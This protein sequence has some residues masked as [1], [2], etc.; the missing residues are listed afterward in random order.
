MYVHP[1][2]SHTIPFYGT[3][4]FPD[5]AFCRPALLAVDDRGPPLVASS[6]MTL[7]PPSLQPTGSK[8]VWPSLGIRG[9]VVVA[10]T[11]LKSGRKTPSYV[12]TLT[13][14]EEER[15]RTQILII[16]RIL[17]VFARQG[18]ACEKHLSAVCVFL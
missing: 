12:I 11:M 4:F 18:C 15:N 2:K 5:I 3:F 10:W 14:A 13:P 1:R 17:H 7:C 8:F 9:K 6:L 16:L